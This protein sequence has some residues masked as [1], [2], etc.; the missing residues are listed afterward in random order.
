MYRAD[1]NAE[2]SDGENVPLVGVAVAVALTVT[3]AVAL[4]GGVFGLF[5]AACVVAVR[6]LGCLGGVER[7]ENVYGV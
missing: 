1:V 5:R 4:T 6:N 7:A 3:F 2:K